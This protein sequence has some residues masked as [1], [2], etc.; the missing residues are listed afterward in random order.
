[1]I[2]KCWMMCVI[3]CSGRQCPPGACPR[4]RAT[5]RLAAHAL[6]NQPTNGGL[7]KDRT[8]WLLSQWEQR[9]GRAEGSTEV[10]QNKWFAGLALNLMG[11]LAHTPLPVHTVTSTTCLPV[12]PAS[13]LPSPA[14]SQDWLDHKRAPLLL[15][16]P[17]GA[18]CSGQAYI[19]LP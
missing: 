18:P 1:M 7:E 4:W 19:Q 12:L 15:G 11:A 6:C 9:R 8:S 10:L 5:T 14:Y 2:R 16:T 17:A 3:S 13:E